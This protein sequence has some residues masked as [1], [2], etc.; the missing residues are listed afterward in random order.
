MLHRRLQPNHC[1]ADLKL[2]T[3]V[4]RRCSVPR[5]PASSSAK[6]DSCTQHAKIFSTVT[7][8]INLGATSCLNASMNIIIM[9]EVV[10]DM[11]VA[12]TCWCQ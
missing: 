12:P 11:I 3:R 9:H 6:N 10:G 1:K 4:V 5:R 2:I 8:V 7:A